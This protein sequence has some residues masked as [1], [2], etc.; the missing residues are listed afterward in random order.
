MRTPY[1]AAIGKAESM[2]DAAL[3][4]LRNIFDLVDLSTEDTLGT[5][6]FE[7]PAHF[8]EQCIKLQQS[9]DSKAWP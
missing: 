9:V 5:F 6:R 1:N 4:T 3:Y 2:H 7:R 8:L